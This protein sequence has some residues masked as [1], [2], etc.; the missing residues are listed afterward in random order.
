MSNCDFSGGLIQFYESNKEYAG[1]GR[2]F[3][4]VVIDNTAL[5]TAAMLD[6]ISHDG[7]MVLVLLSD[8][9]VVAEEFAHLAR[10]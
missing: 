9:D 2:R 8:E 1:R 10:I 4:V 7:A 5:C 6:Q 3:D